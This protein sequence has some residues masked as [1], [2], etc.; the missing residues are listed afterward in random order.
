[1]VGGL[2]FARSPN[3]DAAPTFRRYEV[4]LE[5]FANMDKAERVLN[6]KFL[7][8]LMLTSHAKKTQEIPK[9]KKIF[10]DKNE[11]YLN[12]ANSRDDRRKVAFKYLASKNFRV[13]EYCSECQKQEATPDLPKHKWKFC[14][15]CNVDRKFFNVLSM[16]HKF[17]SGSATLFLSNE[18]IPQVERLKMPAK[19][20]ITDFKEEA[21][22]EKYHYNVK[23]LDI[24]TLESI[25]NAKEKLLNG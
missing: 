6:Y 11:L 17:K 16:H 20:D 25:I 2:L 21:R 24:F 19:A 14:T 8:G 13:I 3:I 1:M 22:F 5:A 12:L 18:L 10:D 7:L 9:R 23:N 4:L 15:E